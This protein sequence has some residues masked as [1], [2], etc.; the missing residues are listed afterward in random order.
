MTQAGLSSLQPSPS[1]RRAL[2]ARLRLRQE[3]GLAL[4]PTLTVVAVLV[5]IQ[6]WSDQRLLF[7]SLASSAFLIY[8]D[9][10]HG[11]NSARTLS[12]AQGVA[13][14][15]GFG[16]QTLL[17]ASYVA[18]GGAMVLVIL[19]MVLLDVVHPPAVS[20]AL[21]FAFRSGP[22]SNLLLFGLAIGLIVVLLALQRAT[23]WLLLHYTR[24]NARSRR[25]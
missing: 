22:E 7:A 9:P 25:G 1:S 12:V 15:L 2:R 20:T 23:L 5:L 11:A 18:A 6:F 13:A 19:L 10:E 17:G 14:L 4:L 21:N 3:L 16:A 8:L 24:F